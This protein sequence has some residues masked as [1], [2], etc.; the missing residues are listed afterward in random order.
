MLDG[1]DEEEEKEGIRRW[2]L[3]M[4]EAQVRFVSEE[5]CLMSQERPPGTDSPCE[6]IV[7]TVRLWAARRQFAWQ[8]TSIIERYGPCCV[9]QVAL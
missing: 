1:V 6:D 2:S 8:A 4:A 7:T 5:P 3:L 9:V